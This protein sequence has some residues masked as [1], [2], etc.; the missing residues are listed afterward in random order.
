VAAASGAASVR[1][2][3]IT[4]RGWGP[5]TERPLPAVVR[6]A[7]LQTLSTIISLWTVVTLDSCTHRNPELHSPSSEGF[8]ARAQRLLDY[9]IRPPQQRRRYR[10]TERLGGLEVDHQLVTRVAGAVY[11]TTSSGGSAAS[12]HLSSSRAPGYASSGLQRRGLSGRCRL[13]C[14]A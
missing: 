4:S 3:H 9:L 11:A 7:I 6:V 10:E 1:V 13:R 5:W 2:W 12:S 14:T 8:W